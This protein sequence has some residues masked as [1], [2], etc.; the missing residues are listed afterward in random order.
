MENIINL[1]CFNMNIVEKKEVG[2]IDI[3]LYENPE[4]WNGK[5]I[6]QGDMHWARVEHSPFA[7]L[8]IHSDFSLGDSRLY[9]FTE[10][11]ESFDRL[12]NK[13]NTAES[14][15]NSCIIMLAANPK[16]IENK[17]PVD[18]GGSMHQFDH[19]V[20]F[21]GRNVDVLSAIDIVN[22]GN[23]PKSL[24]NWLPVDKDKR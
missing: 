7:V 3:I 24:D 6:N 20:V 16:I 23:L 13:I 21:S 14:D 10:D 4:D 1:D 5:T 2:V 19:C 12:I 11:T 9:I 8:V 17:I 15:P 22:D 18:K